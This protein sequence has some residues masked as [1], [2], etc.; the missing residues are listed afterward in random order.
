[1][2]VPSTNWAENGLTHISEAPL[3]LDWLEL[4]GK[5]THTFTHFKLELKVYKSAA[6]EDH[7][8]EGLWV[9]PEK[10]KEQAL[11]TLTK[12]VI[13]HANLGL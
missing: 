2:E 9:L 12:K 8:L 7:Q 6:S 5:V 13:K 4:P 10:L 3:D 1:M 11:P